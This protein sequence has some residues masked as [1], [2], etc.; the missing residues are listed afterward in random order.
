L[1]KHSYTGE[2]TVFGR[3][4]DASYAPL[5]SADG[6]LTGALFVAIAK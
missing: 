5:T 6:Q 2:A 3:K 4:Y 1:A